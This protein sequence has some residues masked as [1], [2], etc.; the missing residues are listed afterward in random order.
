MGTCRKRANGE[1]SL[2]QRSDGKW[3]AQVT[4]GIRPDGK[5]E[6]KSKTFQRKKDANEWMLGFAHKVSCGEVTAVSSIS[7][8]EY[9]EHWL[10][11]KKES[12]S[13]KTWMGYEGDTKNHIVPYFG[14]RKIG[15]IKTM[16]INKFID[17]LAKE[18]GLSG[19]TISGIRATLHNIFVLAIAEEILVRNPVAYSKT[20]KIKKPNRGIID[21]F[22]RK[23][24]FLAAK[25]MQ[26]D[27]IAKGETA[28]R[29]Y[30]LYTFLIIAY[31][32]GMRPEEI[33]ALKWSYIDLE[34]SLIY[35]RE[36]VVEA[37]DLAGDGKI[38]SIAGLPKTECS[39]R[40]ITIPRELAQHLRRLKARTKNNLVIY[41]RNQTY[42]T[43][44][45]ISYVW[46]EVLSDLGM[47]GKYKLYEFRHTHAT[48]LAQ[49]NI[50]LTDIQYRLGHTDIR[51]TANIYTHSN[52]EA[53]RRI[54]ALFDN[55]QNSM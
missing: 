6:R 4:I 50:P 41:N 37:P 39:I 16:H 13:P 35:V 14:D 51:T 31:Y 24:I 27:E 36:A 25:T 9:A 23:K 47:K 53:G 42:L 7:F 46:R 26:N 40:D 55:S 10:E 17:H 52:I 18:K 15:M 49:N 48:I 12:V 43:N 33:L 22:D 2:T 34:H 45:N 11:Y 30:F 19:K 5:F 1:G 3:L 8:A 38:R 20:V 28:G 54:T 44:N 29:R 32:T 21:D